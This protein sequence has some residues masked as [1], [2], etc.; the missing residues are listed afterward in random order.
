MSPWQISSFKR[1]SPFGIRHSGLPKWCHTLASLCFHSLLLLFTFRSF[2]TLSFMMRVI[3]ASAAAIRPPSHP[4]CHVSR[5]IWRWALL[6]LCLC[7]SVPPPHPYPLSLQDINSTVIRRLLNLWWPR[8][9]TAE[10]HQWLKN[11]ES[12]WECNGSGVGPWPLIEL[13]DIGNSE[14]VGDW[15]QKAASEREEGDEEKRWDA[16]VTL[17][18]D[19]GVEEAMTPRT[20][21]S[22]RDDRSFT[23]RV[24]RLCLPNTAS[25]L[26]NST[27]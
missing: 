20:K 18:L 8:H 11:T 25:L 24:D 12:K 5:Q 17:E 15:T 16:R 1:R 27:T 3:S 9:L 2:L 21:T 14:R 26:S 13:K 22:Q 4:L 7:G 10:L 19:R 6:S 23:I